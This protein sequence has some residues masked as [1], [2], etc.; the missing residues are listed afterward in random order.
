M[1]SAEIDSSGQ[2]FY[3]I[4]DLCH[5]D[6][7]KMRARDV[8]FQFDKESKVVDVH[9]EAPKAMHYEQLLSTWSRVVGNGGRERRNKQSSAGQ[10]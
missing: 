5:L 7:I 8:F 6:H 10:A 3:Y 1:R 2:P 9:N 4:Y